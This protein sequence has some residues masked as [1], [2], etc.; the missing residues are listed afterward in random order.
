MSL[1]VIQTEANSIAAS[2]DVF[3][4]KVRIEI[5]EASRAQDK[6]RVKA[7]RTELR[8]AQKAKE[9]ALDLVED[10]I[11][12]MADGAIDELKVAAEKARDYLDDIRAKAKLLETL[13]KVADLAEGIVKTLMVLK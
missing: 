11:L 1:S 3:A 6:D 12:K 10:K 2:F 8:R 13:T 7:L 9:K 5:R 4:R